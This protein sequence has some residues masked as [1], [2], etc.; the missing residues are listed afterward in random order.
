M[1]TDIII[2]LAIL[3]MVVLLAT[4]EFFIY[5]MAKYAKLHKQC[6]QHNRRTTDDTPTD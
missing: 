3:G 1:T 2:I 4:P 5:F 6:A